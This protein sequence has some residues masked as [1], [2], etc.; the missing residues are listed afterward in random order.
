[1]LAVAPGATAAR[2]A[3]ERELTAL[4]G[5]VAVSAADADLLIIIGEPGAELADAHEDV[6]R[7]LP[8]PR[9]RAHVVRPDEARTVLAAATTQLCD[10]R[11]AQQAGQRHDEWQTTDLGGAHGDDGMQMPGGLMMAD[12]SPDRDGLGL[13][14]LRVSWGPVLV[15]WPAGLVMNLTLQGDLVQQAEARVLPAAGSP[16]ESFWDAGASAQR[17]AAAHLDSLGRL[18]SVAGWQGMAHRGYADCATTSW[19]TPRPAGRWPN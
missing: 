13:D 1:M 8:G 6:W 2:L 3:V 9:A 11:Q 5:V 16:A 7:Q 19:R 17:H 4:G 10:P 14:A 15:D 12:R 18:L